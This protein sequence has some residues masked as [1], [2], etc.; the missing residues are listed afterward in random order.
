[1]KIIGVVIN[2]ETDVAKSG[3]WPVLSE[4]LKEQWV[5]KP[6]WMMRRG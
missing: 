4:I 6:A 5:P 2:T 1:M 3:R